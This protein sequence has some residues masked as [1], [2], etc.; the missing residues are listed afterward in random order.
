MY[1]VIWDAYD[2]GDYSMNVE[3]IAELADVEQFVNDLLGGQDLNQR[4]GTSVRHVYEVT[5]EL[6]L[7]PVKVVEEYELRDTPPA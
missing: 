1:V 7:H 5:R 2:S 3:E 4:K 6:Y